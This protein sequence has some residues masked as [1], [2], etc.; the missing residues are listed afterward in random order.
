MPEDEGEKV[1]FKQVSQQP[2]MSEAQKEYKKEALQSAL[3]VTFYMSVSIG[4]VMINRVLLT[5]HEKAGGL[6]MSWYQ[7]IVAYVIIII[8]TNLFPNVPVLNLFPPIKYNISTFLKVIPVSATY[9]GMVGLNNKCLEYVTVSSYQI[10]RSLTI[11]FNII[12]TYIV[13]HQTTSLRA[14]LACLGVVAGF[15]LGIDGEVNLS[16]K[17]AFYG[18]LSS[19]F[20]AL[21]SIVVKKALGLLDN[22]EYLLIEYNTPIAIV[23]LTP[24]V[25]L[26]GE[27][28]I[29]KPMP[30]AQFWIMQTFGGVVGFIINIAIYVNIKYTTPLTHNLSGTVKACLQTLLALL[31]FKNSESM[32]P[33][34]LLG[35]IFIIGFSAYYTYVRKTEMKK[36]ADEKEK[37][38]KLKAES[39]VPISTEVHFEKAEEEEQPQQKPSEAL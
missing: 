29:L 31:F 30:S 26:S 13:L 23:L 15:L 14:I 11:M 20:V 34:K 12:F 39:E 27:F 5:S 3:A 33:K 21:Y 32:P 37:Q 7:F 18:V 28:K 36:R 10:V 38:E 2:N 9:L 6:F 19:I 1:P 17:G 16:I 8:I 25:Y 24:F 4:L 22:N 35:T